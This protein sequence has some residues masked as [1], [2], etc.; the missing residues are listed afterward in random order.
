MA[1]KSI[2]SVRIVS[3]PE[4]FGPTKQS[5]EIKNPLKKNVTLFLEKL[6]SENFTLP[7]AFE[8]LKMK[9]GESARVQVEFH[10]PEK[11]FA[12]SLSANYKAVIN[13]WSLEGAKVKKKELVDVIDLSGTAP[14]LVVLDST[15]C[16]DPTSTSK[17]RSTGRRKK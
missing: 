17:Q 6:G 16:F 10:P 3:R 1:S 9:P 2:D 4:S 5:F 13:V 11:G 12:Y 7:D 15:K 8:K 14:G